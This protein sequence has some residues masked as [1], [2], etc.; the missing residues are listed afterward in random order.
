MPFGKGK[1]W[2]PSKGW[3]QRVVGGWQLNGVCQLQSGLPIIIRGANNSLADRPNSTGTSAKLANPTRNEW[4]DVTQFVNP[5]L[6][7][8][9]NVARTIPDVRGPGAAVVDL[10][11]NKNTPIRERA[12]LQFRAEA[13]NF[14][15][16]T[17]LLE[18][19]GT[20]VPGPNG[21]NQSGSF[22]KITTARDA[23]VIQ[24]G[25]KLLF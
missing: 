7:T 6:Y 11:L 21:T 2:N 9:G 18:P 20:F 25:L 8:I 5:P 24:F 17:N 13:F 14:I 15:N 16:R 10:S 19:N 12:N 3:A 23:R 4:F 22:G 1:R